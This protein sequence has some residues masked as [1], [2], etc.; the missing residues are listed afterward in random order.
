MLIEQSGFHDRPY[1]SFGEMLPM[2]NMEP[3]AP[4]RQP[5]TI[6]PADWEQE[7]RERQEREIHL[8]Q[9]QQVTAIEKMMADALERGE[10]DEPAPLGPAVHYEPLRRL[11]FEEP[12][13]R[14]EELE[15][16]RREEHAL[17]EEH[18]SRHPPAERGAA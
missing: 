1:G 2:P 5:F 11:T 17:A 7:E 8:A 4:A 10:I 14:T 9:E 16:A 6:P 18:P 13:W 15:H 3:P 12:D